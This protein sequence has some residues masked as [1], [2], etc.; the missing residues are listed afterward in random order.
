MINKDL[1]QKKVYCLGPNGTFSAMAAKRFIGNQSIKISPVR[2]INEVFQNIIEDDNSFGILPIENTIAGVVG[3]HQDL[4]VEYCK[5]N[6]VVIVADIYCDIRFGLI[7]NNPDLSK[8]NLFY[9]HPHA[10]DQCQRFKIKHMPTAQ[11]HF[12]SST[13]AASQI[14]T[15][16]QAKDKNIAAIIPLSHIS[17]ND[18]IKKFYVTTNYPQ[19]IQDS[20]VNITRFFVIKKKVNPT[21]NFDFSFQK[22]SIFIESLKDEPSL[23]HRIL[24]PFTSLKI[25]LSFLHSRSSLDNPWTYN[26]F[27]DFYNNPNH[28][29]DTELMLNTLAR[30]DAIKVLVLGSYDNLINHER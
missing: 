11:A 6:D 23:L 14:F 29:Q 3:V 2:V 26:F 28:A 12:V 24:T 16:N 22:A 17:H 4:L 18:Q 7:A 20:N 21:I 25:N 1:P 10:I 5:K 15:Q 13:T 27:L 9:A 8:I 30:F 19:G